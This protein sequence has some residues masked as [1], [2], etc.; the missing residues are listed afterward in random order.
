MA[1]TGSEPNNSGCAFLRLVAELR[2]QIYQL[3]FTADIDSDLEEVDLI[4]AHPPAAGGLLLTCRQINSEAKGIYKHNLR[5]YWLNTHFYILE[6][7]FDEKIISAKQSFNHSQHFVL[8]NH[9]VL[10]ARDTD[11]WA[12]HTRGHNGAWTTLWG[13]D[14]QD[15]GRDAYRGYLRAF[16]NDFWTWDHSE[17]DSVSLD[18]DWDAESEDEAA[19]DAR[20]GALPGG[21]GVTAAELRQANSPKHH[22]HTKNTITMVRGNDTQTKVH[23]KGSNDDFV[24]LVD[25]TKAVQDWKNDSSIPLAQVVSGWKVFVTH[26]HGNHGILDT[27]SKGILEDEFGT[28]K[29]E[30]VVKQILEKGTIIETE[31]KGRQ[32]DKNLSDGP[33]QAH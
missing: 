4:H 33:R 20:A 14:E 12:T 19:A 21:L 7:D 6:D 16:I 18:A 32:G 8:I 31:E 22:I 5:A 28:S 2:N 30:E 1:S 25:S 29:D 11:Y 15:P 10:H 9:L 23:Y 13:N 17:A 26:K 27:A 3:V 24:I